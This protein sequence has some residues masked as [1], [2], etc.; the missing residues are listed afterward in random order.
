MATTPRGI[1]FEEHEGS[2]TIDIAPGGVAGQRRF[3][4][5]WSDWDAFAQEVYGIYRDVGGLVVV[6]APIPFPG[7]RP[8]LLP[9]TMHVEP[10]AGSA[11]GSPVTTLSSGTNGYAK[12]LVTVNYRE[13]FDDRKDHPNNPDVPK[14][15]YVTYKGDLSAE[16]S[17][18]PGR[19][20]MWE[21][22]AEQL[23]ADVMPAI[24]TPTGN[25]TLTWRRVL[26][27]PHGVIG[28]LRGKVNNATFMGAPAG[29][30][31]FLGGQLQRDFQPSDDV[32][33][34]RIDYRFLEKRSYL[35]NGMTA[36]GWNYFFNSKP[37]SGNEHWQRITAAQ[38]VVGNEYPYQSADFNTLFQYE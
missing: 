34:W 9:D 24:L 19:T 26:R 37:D 29:C 5:D 31:L 25:F 33:I 22:L 35:T 11:D 1:T 27:P 38:S 6:I 32:P 8:W 18:P 16:Y 14:G 10:Y 17:S 7:N 15:T 2:P 12:A 23:P 28:R 36:V 30:V 4:V 13:R 21:N 3:V 20:W